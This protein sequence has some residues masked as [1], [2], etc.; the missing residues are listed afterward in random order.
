[1]FYDRAEDQLDTFLQGTSEGEGSERE[2]HS[3]T[4]AI[5]KQTPVISIVP[6]QVEKEEEYVIPEVMQTEEVLT[7]K[8]IPSYYGWPIAISKGICECTKT[9]LY[10]IS[11]YVSYSQVSP[12]YNRVIKH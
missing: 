5:S 8:D 12:E 7:N 4:P 1:M 6:S 11:N 2:D 10:L 3:P 9:K